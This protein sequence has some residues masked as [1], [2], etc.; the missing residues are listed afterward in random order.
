MLHEDLLADR[1]RAVLGLQTQVKIIR[2]FHFGFQHGN[3]IHP[4]RLPASPVVGSC[5]SGSVLLSAWRGCHKHLSHPHLRGR[6][7]SP[8]QSPPLT[9]SPLPAPR[10]AAPCCRRAAASDG[11]RPASASSTGRVL[12]V[13]LHRGLH[14]LQIPMD[15]DADEH[16]RDSHARLKTE[17]L[18]YTLRC[19]PFPRPS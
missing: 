7:I 3:S 17:M 1:L 14:C 15:I 2:N 12:G 11:S 9:R 18:A 13:V 6:L 10:S 5:P 4:Y 19:R 8:F 16:P